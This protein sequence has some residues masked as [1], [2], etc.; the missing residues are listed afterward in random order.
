MLWKDEN[1]VTFDGKHNN[2]LSLDTVSHAFETKTMTALPAVSRKLSVENSGDIIDKILYSPN[3]YVTT[4][5]APNTYS[6]MFL[7]SLFD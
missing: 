1:S 7:Y 4:N 5:P 6:N 3:R 2:G